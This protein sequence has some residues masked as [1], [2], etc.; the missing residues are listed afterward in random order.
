MIPS[1][2]VQ[3]NFQ[4]QIS[5][6]FRISIDEWMDETSHG[7]QLA[8]KVKLLTN[9]SWSA[10][11]DFQVELVAETA[12]WLDEVRCFRSHSPGPH[13]CDRT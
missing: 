9:D 10:I 2:L 11:L 12:V 4:G 6:V 3:L 7:A 5:M 8:A 13:R 1:D